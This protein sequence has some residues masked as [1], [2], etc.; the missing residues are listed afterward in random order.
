MPQN[1]KHKT[2]ISYTEVHPKGRRPYVRE[3]PPASLCNK[4]LVFIREDDDLLTPYD[5][6][7]TCPD[8]L[9]KLG[10]RRK[11]NDDIIA[12]SRKCDSLKRKFMYEH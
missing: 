1:N 9:E 11:G 2:V 6:D 3:N 5:E 8:C 4:P 7:V 10:G 12:T